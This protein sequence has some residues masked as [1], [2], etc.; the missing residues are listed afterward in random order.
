M[1]NKSIKV[2]VIVTVHNAEKYLRECM[3]S[4]ITQSLVD[5]EILCMG[6]GSSDAS[7]QILQEYAEKDTRIR[8]IE[9]SNTSYGHKVNRGIKEARGKYISVLESDDMYEVYM[10][11]KLYNIAVRYSPDFVNADYTCFFDVNGKRFRSVTKMYPDKDYNHL[12]ENRRHPEEFGVIP[13]Y[14]TGIFKKDF[15]EREK[16][17][18]NESPGA[19]YQDMSFRFLT[20]VLAETSFHLDLPVYLYRTDNPESSMHDCKKTIVIAEE[21]NFL[22]HELQKRN[23]RNRY[24]WHNA[25]QWKY[26][27]FLGNMRYLQEP[28]RQELFQRYQEE[29]IKDRNIL[30]SFADMEWLN[31][32]SEMITQSP[33]KIAKKI[34]QEAMA[35]REHNN[36]LSRFLN[37]IT[38]LPVGQQ[39]VLFGCGQRGESALKYLQSAECR[40]VCLTDNAEDLWNTEKWGYRVLDPKVAVQTYGDAFY[41]IANKL[42]SKD[43][44]EQLFEMGIAGEMICKY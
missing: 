25:Y 26:L 18:M 33:E 44:A 15:L 24:I 30:D 43:I 27:D 13:R 40:I 38:N 2:S 42:N 9:D 11:E 17:Q 5:I 16:I 28:Y 19:S 35:I 12:M 14:W 39:V 22:Y 36:Y 37:Q 3:E 6:G 7:P 10:L 29:L 32:V 1:K 34:E 4:V 8:I 20:S 31:D 21:H 23:I 41:V